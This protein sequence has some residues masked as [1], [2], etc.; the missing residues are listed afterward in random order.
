MR[1]GLMVPRR[2]G[3]R[4]RR[5]TTR[6]ING[7]DQSVKLNRGLWAMAEYLAELPAR[8]RLLTRSKR[9][10]PRL[11]VM[12]ALMRS[13]NQRRNEDE[14]I[15]RR[16]HIRRHRHRRLCRDMQ[17]DLLQFGRLFDLP[18]DLLLIWRKLRPLLF[19]NHML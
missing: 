18:Y 19:P 11:P 16:R 8:R 5:Q 3:H 10:P 17:Y 12:R 13:A 9:G 7:I 14:N 15:P 2:R 4:D 6:E 1:G